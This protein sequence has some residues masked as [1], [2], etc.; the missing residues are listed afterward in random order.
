MLTLDSQVRCEPTPYHVFGVCH[1]LNLGKTLPTFIRL[2]ALLV[3]GVSAVS[4]D[5][6]GQNS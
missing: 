4:R 2:L 1:L 5:T 3:G 6:A